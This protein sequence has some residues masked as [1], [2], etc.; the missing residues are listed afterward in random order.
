VPIVLWLAL[1]AALAAIT[2]R[3]ADWF[4]M[5]DEL[6]YER[7]ALSIAR[8]HSPLPR[9]HGELVSNIN[10]LYPLIIAPLY[11]HGAI[12]HGFHET[13]VLNAFVMSSA[14]LPAYLLARRVSQSAWLPFVVAIATVVVPWI[15]L[16]SFLLTEVAAY[17][18]FV[19]ALLGSQ[20]AISKPSVR[21]DV[22]A[23]AGIALAVLARTQFY[24]LAAILPIALLG[25]ATVEHRLKET[26]RTHRALVV[27]YAIGAVAAI[28]LAATGHSPLGTYSQTTSGNPLP[29]R[30][31][32]LAPAHLAIVALAGGLL[33]FLAGGAWLVSN[34][35][36]SESV[37]RASFAWLGLV[38]VVVLTLEVASFDVRFGG[39]VIRERYLFYLTPLL[40]VALS[41]ALT[42]P[43][44]PRWSLAVPVAIGAFGFWQAPLPTFVKLNVDTPASVLNDWLLSTMHGVGGARAFLV[45]VMVVLALVF[46]ECAALL[47]RLP[48][49][50]SLSALLLVA[51]PAETG[52]AFKRLFAVD[53]TAG[54]PL[55]LD[56][57]VVFG[58]VDREITTN[59]EAVMVPY[60]VLRADYW[61]SVGFWWDLEF[62]NKSV[63]REAA[64]DGEF[65]GTP[66]GSFPKLDLRFDPRTGRANVDLDSYIAQST[67]DA[68]FHVAG[69]FLVTE[70]GV[71]IVFP[72]R[73]W[74]ADWVSYGLYDDGWTRPGTT[75]RIRVF[76]VPGQ[77][78]ALARP[79]TLSLNAP[80]D[81][82]SRSLTI[83]SGASVQRVAIT[84]AV[85]QQAVSV[86]V[87][88]HGFTDV[89]LRARGSSAIYG[90]P[91]TVQSAGLPRSAGVL[92][93][94]VSLGDASATRCVVTGPSLGTP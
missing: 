25:R 43:R 47:P 14:A 83:R 17:P 56:Q 93:G 85:V 16:S 60:P 54:L 53:G 27:L 90:D 92:V 41:A 1:G 40:L 29:L 67:A 75:A 73:P 62:W 36:R 28:A 2:S 71:S 77:K 64:P 94:Q 7:L 6:L 44:W 38:T 89:S 3:V 11:R 70:R 37:E 33:P 9:V 39:G 59:S 20:A 23:V 46:I 66:S 91:T 15:T 4:V 76:A 74:R 49:A 30:I 81:V 86:C 87:P 31:F 72:D 57:S 12:L 45:L 8:T 21:N 52:Y 88:P 34:V 10:Q 13:H 48:V 63:D 42:A 19:W 65:S 26:V 55:T 5:T 51:L 24:A 79:L 50:I 32:E 61:A 80:G 69:R 22:L 84:Q 78:T 18:A 35:V 58:W 82:A 68:R